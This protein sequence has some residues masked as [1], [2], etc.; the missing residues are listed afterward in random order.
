MLETISHFLILES[1]FWFCALLGSLLF[2]FKSLFSFLPLFSSETI[3]EASENQ[4]ETL[5]KVLS[6][7]SIT[8]FLMV[9]GWTGLAGLHQFGLSTGQAVLVACVCGCMMLLLVCYLFKGARKLV[10]HG[11]VFSISQTVGKTGVVYQRIPSRGVGKIH[12]SIDGFFYEVD[13]IV[14]GFQEVPSFAQIEVIDTLDENCVI[15]K[16]FP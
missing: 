8:G 11:A 5:F 1:C 16:P 2:L 14:Q 13:A 7:H 3:E 6:I 12:L 4:S 9:F 15:V 10:S